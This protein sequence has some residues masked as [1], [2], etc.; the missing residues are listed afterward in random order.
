MFYTHSIYTKF[1][2][3]D[4]G[5]ALLLPTSVYLLTKTWTP[6]GKQVVINLTNIDETCLSIE[7]VREV[8]SALVLKSDQILKRLKGRRVIKKSVG[9]RAKFINSKAATQLLC[10]H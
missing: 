10:R 1:T 9:E 2:E 4:L 7:V 5:L 8:N 6:I 3:C